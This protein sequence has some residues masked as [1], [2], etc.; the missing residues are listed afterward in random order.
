MGLEGFDAEH[1]VLLACALSARGADL[2]GVAARASREVRCWEGLARSAAL[3]QLRPQ[4]AACLRAIELSS[5]EARGIRAELEEVA[6]A[7]RGHGLMISA[8]LIRILEVLRS[9]AIPAVPFKGPAFAALLGA[10]PAQREAG[11]LDILIE[12]A[13]IGRAVEALSVLGYESALAGAALRSAWLPRA[14]NELGLLRRS[15]SMLVELHWRLAPS[16]FAVPAEVGDVLRRLGRRSFFGAEIP[17]PDAESLFL[18]HVADG[19][20][21]GGCGIRWIGDLVAILR[22]AGLDWAR[23]IETAQRNGALDSVRIAL[24]VA[25]QV[26]AA[27]SPGFDPPPAARLIARQALERSRSARAVGSIRTRLASDARLAGPAAHFCW[28][29]QVGDKPAAVIGAIARHLLGPA[30]ADLQAMPAEGLSDLGLRFRALR[31]RLGAA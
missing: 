11:D 4:L 16:W 1:R 17:W 10:G 26:A 28:A 21:S 29:V 14:T 13:N 6:G 27:G 22:D 18:I 8:E 15:D 5:P 19:M 31:R 25:L 20:K 7:H 9:A 12:E 2:A 23:V 30:L 24:A 3:N